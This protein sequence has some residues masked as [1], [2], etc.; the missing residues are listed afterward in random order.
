MTTGKHI[1]QLK[2]VF[3]V[4][5]LSIFVYTISLMYIHYVTGD[6]PS[7][8]N[9]VIGDS[10]QQAML[11][12]TYIFAFFLCFYDV[13]YYARLEVFERSHLPTTTISPGIAFLEFVI[14]LALVSVVALKVFK[15]EALNDLFFFSAIVCLLISLWLIYLRLFKIDDVKLLDLAPNITICALSILAAYFASAPERQIE[16]AIVV[17]IVSLLLSILLAAG[18]I[19]LTFRFGK[20]LYQSASIFLI[21]W[22]VSE[23]IPEPIISK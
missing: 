19:Y 21:Q 22:K 9:G 4:L 1:R 16:N 17:L 8:I 7:I 11:W 23:P 15:Y 12:V 20:D 18:V 2:P 5:Y 10:N 6:A 3:P 13:L 14:R